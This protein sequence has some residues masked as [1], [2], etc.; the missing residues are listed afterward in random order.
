MVLSS[1]N[2][3][4]VLI[5]KLGIILKQSCEIDSIDENKLDMSY[6]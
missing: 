2:S 4:N 3:S 6:Y 5:Y 1:F